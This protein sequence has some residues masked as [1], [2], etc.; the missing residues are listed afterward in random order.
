MNRQIA[1]LQKENQE[2]NTLLIIEKKK[3]AETKFQNKLMANSLALSLSNV[4]SQKS[5]INAAI[6]MNN[7]LDMLQENCQAATHYEPVQM[8]AASQK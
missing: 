2:V 6:D 7:R 8:A 3:H 5:I 4:E 1:C